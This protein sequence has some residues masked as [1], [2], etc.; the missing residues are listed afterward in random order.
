MEGYTRINE[1]IHRLVIPYKTIFT[2]VFLLQDGDNAVLFDA[3]SCDS[4]MDKRILPWLEDLGVVELT[5][6]FISH[7]HGD[8]AGGLKRLLQKFPRIQ[9]VSCSP[10][11]TREYGAFHSYAPKD[12]EKISKSLQTV[13][14]SGHTLDAIGLLDLRTKTLI[15]G[16][17]LQLHGIFGSD[18]WGANISFPAEHLQAVEKVR[19][20]EIEKIFWAHRYEPLGLCAEG[21]A[22]IDKALDACKDPLLRVRD[23]ILAYPMEND[24]GIRSR[25]NSIGRP[26]MGEHVVTAIRKAMKEGMIPLKRKDAK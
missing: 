23:L 10:S 18:F 2:T 25:Y 15:T 9:I 13:H 1:H 6:V 11:L 19:S 22:A 5:H 17:C 24:A 4:D 20:L 8:H 12:G 21:R 16:D 7:N 3:A 14:I 26:L